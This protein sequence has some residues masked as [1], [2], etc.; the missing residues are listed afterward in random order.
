[1]ALPSYANLGGLEKVT[2]P[3]ATGL[4]PPS[5]TLLVV[6]TGPEGEVPGP[7]ER[8]QCLKNFPPG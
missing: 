3:A 7:S 1:M 2:G 6:V 5:R 4:T 8:V